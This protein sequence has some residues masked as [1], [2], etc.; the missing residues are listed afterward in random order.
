LVP[1]IG[2]VSLT[3]L[4]LL[5]GL[6]ARVGGARVTVGAI[7]VLLWGAVAMGTTAGVGSLFRSST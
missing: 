1:C 2:A 4:A 7:R 5:G 3:F 6:A